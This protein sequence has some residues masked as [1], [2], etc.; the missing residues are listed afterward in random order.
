AVL[1]AGMLGSGVASAITWDMRNA[2]GCGSS[3]EP[4]CSS[5]NGNTRQYTAGGV[6]LTAAAYS[7]T[8]SG[9]G[10]ARPIETAYLGY[11]SSNGLG[12]TN[13]DESSGSPN[14]TVD[15]SSRFDAVRLAF[16]TSVRMT[17][18][19]FGWGDGDTDFTVLYWTGPGSAN[20][21]GDTYAGLSPDWKL[22]NHYDSFGTGT[23]NLGNSSVFSQYWIVMAYNDVFTGNSVNLDGNGNSPDEGDDYFKLGK[24]SVADQTRKVPEPGSLALLGLGLV[25]LGASRRRR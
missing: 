17:D 16:D 10:D 20:P 18:V 8:G 5:S 6:K 14:H 12:V 11:Y 15:N 22:L 2:D 3:G 13:Q 25:G 21:V 1:A 9:S 19:Y 24:V 4:T 23:K 7:D